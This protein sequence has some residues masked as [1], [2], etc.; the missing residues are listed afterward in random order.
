MGGVVMR[1]AHAHLRK[2]RSIDIEAIVC[3]GSPMLRPV[4]LTD[5]W[6]HQVYR[7]YNIDTSDNTA[8]L[9]IA[10][11]AHDTQIDSADSRV[12]TG[13]VHSA[14]VVTVLTRALPQV[15]HSVGHQAL[16]WCTPLISALAQA[17]KTQFSSVDGALGASLDTDE[18]AVTIA[19]TW[20]AVLLPPEGASI[21]DDD[22]VVLS[23]RF[24]GRLV[25]SVDD[26]PMEVSNPPVDTLHSMKQTHLGSRHGD[27]VHV[28]CDV[29]DVV[30]HACTIHVPRGS[31]GNAILVNNVASVLAS[32]FLSQST[33][34]REVLL[35]LATDAVYLVFLP[36]LLPVLSL[37]QVAL[38]RAA[39]YTLFSTASLLL[40]MTEQRTVSADDINDLFWGM[41]PPL[42]LDTLR[43]C[44]CVLLLRV[45]ALLLSVFRRFNLTL[46]LLR[47]FA[48]L[49]V[50]PVI[51]T[52]LDAY[53]PIGLPVWL[54]VHIALAAYLA[55]LSSQRLFLAFFLLASLML[56]LP[57]ALPRETRSMP[58]KSL[59]LLCCELSDVSSCQTLLSITL[60][61]C[62]LL[63][64]TA[65][66]TTLIS[67]AFTTFGL[68]SKP[69]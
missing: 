43:V 13:S 37:R 44:L 47:L 49:C 60:S 35:H 23:R 6:M 10:G 65:L 22:T 28:F 17:L 11:G 59:W 58:L 32:A 50:I 12:L 2:T 63:P 69:S 48:L 24:L 66:M 7:S 26:V 62:L 16:T 15:D 3:I 1:S 25:V 14:H 57:M 4:V 36:L 52:L 55:S 51:H 54:C 38:L 41:L 67:R 21:S 56:T 34:K 27:Q 8:L 31:N 19:S 53:A 68:A 29:H 18:R 42:I 30:E 64:L 45:S 46:T 61:Q 20:R 33:R 40:Q 5:W 9:A 39:A